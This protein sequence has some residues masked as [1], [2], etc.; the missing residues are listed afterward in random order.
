M[1]ASLGRMP[2]CA[3]GATDAGAEGDRGV[4]ASLGRMPHRARGETGAPP[5]G[6]AA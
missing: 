3:P 2:H 6:V 1:S 4:S 5:Q